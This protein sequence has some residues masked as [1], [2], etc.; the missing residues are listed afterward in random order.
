MRLHPTS[1]TT[2]TIRI[3]CDTKLL[4]PYG[5]L[6]GIQGALKVMTKENFAKLR[7]QILA[8][9]VNFPLHVWL[10][11]KKSK[12]RRVVKW[13]IIDGHGRHAVIKFL[14]EEEGMSC[15]PLPCVAIQAKSFKEAKEQ[16]LA[17]SSAYHSMVKEGLYEF[18]SGLGLTIEQMEEFTLPEIDMPEYKM[19]YFGAPE[20]AE[21]GEKKAVTFDAYK[22]ATVKQ[23]VLYFAAGE[24]EKVIKAMDELVDKWSLEDYS[25]VVWRLLAEKEK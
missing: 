4:I 7:R 14:V 23:V 9:G 6:H 25:Q 15:G 21:E 11:R 16:V 18:Q 8:K 2:K 20:V 13:W 5:E 10:E 19:E 22:N 3:T 12:G 24:Y 17:A 1:P